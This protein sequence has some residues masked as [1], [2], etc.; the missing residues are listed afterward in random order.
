MESPLLTVGIIFKNE[1]RCIERCLQSLK[2]LREAVPCQIILVDTGATDGS[3][4]IA[5]KYADLLLDFEWIDDFSAARNAAMDRATG[6]WYMS[7]DCDE[8]LGGNIQEL[9]EF[10]RTNEDYD[11]GAVNIRN[12]K[13]LDLDKSGEYTDFSACRLLRMSTGLRFIG[14]I[15]ERFASKP[16]GSQSVLLLYRV[17]FHHDGYVHSSFEESKK[18]LERN[19]QLLTKRLEES[20]KDPLLLLQCIES[21]EYHPDFQ[22][23][24]KRGIRTVEEHTLGW[25]LFGPPILRYAVVID[26]RQSLPE[27]DEDIARAER[28]FPDSIYTRIDVGFI[29]FGQCWNR[30][31]YTEC[32][33][34]GEDY[35]QA[36]SDYRSGN[37]NIKES[38]C[39][40]LVLAS[41]SWETQLRIFLAASYLHENQ[42]EKCMEIL[43]SLDGSQMNLKHVADVSRNYV[44][45]HSKSNLDTAPLLLQLWEQISKAAPNEEQ[46]QQR[47]NEFI[48][49]NSEVFLPAYLDREVER[50][51]FQRHAYT[52]FLPLAGQCVLG[53]AA[54]MLETGN[55][56]VLSLKLAEL[57]DLKMLPPHVL[58][59]ALEKGAAFPPPGR[60]FKLEELDV[61]GNRL[62]QDRE[63]LYQL[64][65]QTA[66]RVDTQ[67]WME[68]SWSRSLALTA[69]QTCDWSDAAQRERNL[70]II[71]SFGRVEKRFLPCCYAPEALTEERLALLPPLHR[72]GWYCAQAFDALDGGDA[73]QYVRLLRGSI[74][75][76]PGAKQIVEF[77]LE[78][79]E[80][81]QYPS[82]VTDNSSELAA[83]ADQVRSLLANY[84]PD[85]PVVAEIKSSPAYK[86]VAWLIEEPSVLAQ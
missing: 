80:Q 36:L 34:R 35:L 85:D 49:M 2:P 14:S 31:E 68:L 8:W 76:F 38:L 52:L 24:I 48:R 13:T 60:E 65:V 53:D 28:M 37:F 81:E 9:I 82:A 77:L 47:Q 3:R 26:Y 69:I 46:A 16:D 1:I 11:Y 6:K 30:D 40:T 57:E 18:K 5:E 39:S 54:E 32:I 73:V 61:I 15:H 44:S 41:S 56:D 33:S 50:G 58:F 67:N 17:L 84:S 72:F 23:F 45:L 66:G 20:P 62:A 21:G 83:L 64:T 70:S 63:E 55:A 42:Y 79:V 12:Y 86:K 7:I 74:K 27:I 19:M 29:A 43:A 59:H 51:D 71:R 25:K 10:I 22:E 4:Q 75:T 78:Q